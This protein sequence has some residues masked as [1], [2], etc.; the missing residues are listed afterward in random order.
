MVDL[1][2]IMANV[3]HCNIVVREFE[4]QSRYYDHFQTNTLRNDMNPL[5]TQLLVK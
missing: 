3:L 4:F 5:F 1:S 2:G